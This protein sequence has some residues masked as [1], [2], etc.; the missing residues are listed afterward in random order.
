MGMVRRISILG[1]TG[2]IGRSTVDVLEALGGHDVYEV[3]TVTGAANIGGLADAA[4]RLGARVA[5]T[6]CTS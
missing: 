4:R 6:A 3:Q 5:V 2:S 1:V